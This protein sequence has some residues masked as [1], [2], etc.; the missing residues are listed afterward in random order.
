MAAPAFIGFLPLLNF[1]I[2]ILEWIFTK[3]AARFTVR[4]AASIA[5]ITFYIALLTAL[6]VTFTVILAAIS[7]ALPSDL[8]RGMAMIKPS[9]LEACIGAIYAAKLSMWV[10]HQKKQII[11]WEQ[12]RPF[13]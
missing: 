11:D 1:F 12:M 2:R 10:F 13:I 9:N 8:E 5:W 3:V 6:A 7:I 4:L